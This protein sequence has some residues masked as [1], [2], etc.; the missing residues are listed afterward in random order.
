[1]PSLSAL[2]LLSKV[3]ARS[4]QLGVKAAVGLAFV[5]GTVAVTDVV[6]VEVRPLSSVTGSATW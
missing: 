6:F 2:A 4:V 5:T 3:Q 1:M